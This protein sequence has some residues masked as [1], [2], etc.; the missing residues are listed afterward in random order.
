MLGLLGLLAIGLFVAWTASVIHIMVVLTHPPRRGYAWAVARSR[1]SEPGELPLPLTHTSWMFRW[2]GMEFEVWDIEGGAQEGPSIVMIHGWGESRVMSLS[3]VQAIA[4]P[5]RRIIAWDLPGHGEAPGICRLGTAEVDAV[6][7]LLD[8]LACHDDRPVVLFGWSLGAGVAIA[9]AMLRPQRV[10]R[11]IAEA[12]Y[13]IPPTP[14]R[15][16][17]RLMRMPYRATLPPAMWMLG[18]VFAGSPRWRGRGGRPGFDRAELAAKVA[19]PLL[20]LHGGNDD[21]CPVEDGRAIAE[22]APHGECVVLEG[23]AHQSLWEDAHTAEKCL[24]AVRRFLER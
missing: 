7:T 22:A 13:R 4:P 10:S 9:A 12:P 18:L 1:A 5:T 8:E 14:A 24:A 3:R 2:R 19:C 21:V 23:G 15:N 16:V 20:V 17:L 6:V 11:V